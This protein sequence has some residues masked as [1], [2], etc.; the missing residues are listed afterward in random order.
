ML[1]PGSQHELPVVLLVDDDL[2]SREVIA[3]ILT[4]SGYM[5][6][7]ADNGEAAV[8]LL[9]ARVCDP[10]VVLA[11]VQMPGL[12]GLQLIAALRGLCARAALY[13]ISGS[14]PPAEMAA[15]ADGVLLKP[16]SPAELHRLLQGRS[17]QTE[18]SF[19]DSSRPVVSAEMIRQFRQM[20]PEPAIREIYSAMA[21]DLKR[22]IE[23]LGIAI[24]RHDAAE[25]RRI[26]H[27]IKG[28]CGMAGALQAAHLG[29]LLEASGPDN[30]Q[31]DNSRALLRDLR[32]AAQALQRMLEDELPA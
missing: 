24:S 14:Q 18:V 23:A 9:K 31:L 32:T 15:V 20:M 6:H 7:T 29:E 8:A 27:A 25:V 5:V 30:N 12:S 13:L 17:P 16:F 2:V 21:A 3:T 19:L 11:D 26:G 4:L 1:P 22:R 10:G 28:G